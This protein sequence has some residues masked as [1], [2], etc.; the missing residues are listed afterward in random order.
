M[1]LIS[2]FRDLEQVC[3]RSAA[4]AVVAR[5]YDMPAYWRPI[6]Q[7]DGEEAG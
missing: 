6:W 1:T 4:R 3:L 7:E 2:Q 5:H